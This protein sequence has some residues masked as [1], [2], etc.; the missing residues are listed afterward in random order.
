MLKYDY[1]EI[2][3][4]IPVAK[5]SKILK[6]IVYIFFNKKPFGSFKKSLI[7]T[8]FNLYLWISVQIFEVKLLF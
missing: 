5:T 1:N 3:K 2:S 7:W 8:H 6:K 4:R